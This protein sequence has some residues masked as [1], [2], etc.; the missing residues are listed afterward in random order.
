M[1]TA[2]D[3][4]RRLIKDPEYI[5]RED[6]ARGEAEYRARQHHNNVRAL[7][8]AAD[9]SSSI[10]SA[11]TNLSSFLSQTVTLMKA[12]YNN[13]GSAMSGDIDKHIGAMA[14]MATLP[15]AVQE[16]IGTLQSNGMPLESAQ[17][18]MELAQ[19]HY[20]DPDTDPEDHSW[21]NSIAHGIATHEGLKEQLKITPAMAKKLVT[22][23]NSA[24]YDL[25]P[26]YQAPTIKSSLKDFYGKNKKPDLESPATVDNINAA[27]KKMGRLETVQLGGTNKLKFTGGNSEQWKNPFPDK[28]SGRLYHSMIEGNEPQSNT[29]TI[30]SADLENYTVAQI[31]HGLHNY[32]SLEGGR[33]DITP[34]QKAQ[35]QQAKIDKEKEVAQQKVE[36][37]EILAT[38][39]SVENDSIPDNA[40]AAKEIYSNDVKKDKDAKYVMWGG[41]LNGYHST[42]KDGVAHGLCTVD[43][44]MTPLGTMLMHHA[45]SD[46]WGHKEHM[47]Y[48]KKTNAYVVTID[49]LHNIVEKFGLLP[50]KNMDTGEYHN[51]KII[52]EKINDVFKPL[53]DFD[54]GLEHQIE[55]AKPEGVPAVPIPEEE[56][57]PISDQSST[58]NAWDEI[59]NA[60]SMLGAAYEE[61]APQSIKNNL[62]SKLLDSLGKFNDLDQFGTSS[63]DM[64]DNVLFNVSDEHKSSVLSGIVGDKIAQGY[65]EIPYL[66]DH[67]VVKSIHQL[68]KA[69]EN[70][71]HS[72]N[73]GDGTQ[74]GFASA[75]GALED[76]KSSYGMGAKKIAE[77]PKIMSDLIKNQAP[78]MYEYI[79]DQIDVHKHPISQLQSMWEHTG[80]DPS[81]PDAPWNSPN[82]TEVKEKIFSDAMG[83][84]AST[85]PTPPSEESFH[86]SDYGTESTPGTHMVIHQNEDGQ[87][88]TTHVKEAT[89]EQAEG[90]ASATQGDKKYIGTIS[91]SSA[92]V[93]YSS[94]KVAEKMI[95]NKGHGQVHAPEISTS[96][97]TSTP[98][99]EDTVTPTATTTETPTT[100][101]AS[102]EETE[103]TATTPSTEEP[104][105]TTPQTPSSDEE[106]QVTQKHNAKKEKVMSAIFGD[107]LD[108]EDAQLYGEWLDENPKEVAGAYKQHVI[109][110][111]LNKIK[112]KAKN[113][114]K[115]QAEQIKQEKKQTEQEAAET[116]A[117]SEKD[118][119]QAVE[120]ANS[121]PHKLG[122]LKKLSEDDNFSSV[123]A[124]HHARE[125][126]AHKEK[127]GDK[128]KASTK[129]IMK[130]LLVEASEHGAD[131]NK[132]EDEMKEHGENFGSPEHM[133]AAHTADL[134]DHDKH[135]NYKD[136][137]TSQD[138]KHRQSREDSFHHGSYNKFTEFDEDGKP[139]T[140]T[141]VAMG[142]DG[143]AKKLDHKD[144]DVKPHGE[145]KKQSF[146]T[147]K[148]HALGTHHSLETLDPHQKFLADSYK[149]ATAKGDDEEAGKM[150]DKLEASGAD[151]SA[152]IG[153][154]H[155]DEKPKQGPPDPE[156]ARKKMAEGYVWHEETRH[157][158]KKETLD[159]LHG[160]HGA[161]DAS[162][163]S[164]SHGGENPFAFNESGGGSDKNFLLHGSGN[165]M[166]VG[167]AGAT[168]GKSGFASHNDVVENSL[169]HAL[170]ESG[171]LDGH[172]GVQHIPNFSH[173]TKGTNIGKR[174]GFN[175]ANKAHP[176]PKS[177]IASKVAAYKG[178][179]AEAAQAFKA[180][181]K[182]AP[183]AADMDSAVSGAV[184][185]ALSSL[186]PFSK[187]SLDSDDALQRFVKAYA[188]EDHHLTRKKK[189]E[190]ILEKKSII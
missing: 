150:L 2:N 163:I 15:E 3:I 121:L 181:Q 61:D 70:I 148:G 79:A 142:D 116:A 49:G 169:A 151:V 146:H 26:A 77:N 170:T 5:G 157:W 41:H 28:S 22:G 173:P 131:F 27:L 44:A 34:E 98:D 54:E 162:L 29:D 68:H 106:D 96:K 183:T 145:H 95:E 171:H 46:G 160:G 128:M 92:G 115:E 134:K 76:L 127:Y 165:L 153:D 72:F 36:E 30:S 14:N 184:S 19:N 124:T 190:E 167:K 45:K 180:G 137:L 75:I 47:Y 56:Q 111:V 52:Q 152:I 10:K 42:I 66:D 21:L 73:N 20:N 18:L 154:H 84:E 164:S 87:Y 125:L 133:D 64:V 38:S 65:P 80:Q 50:G 37:A 86:D 94:Q 126:L 156:V 62:H 188:S 32:V 51:E 135:T 117:Q 67:P 71:E 189:V 74:E 8:M 24:G 97:P 175:G 119:Q 23:L 158:I 90:L 185:S 35:H 143:R 91:D 13:L 57:E 138:S 123:T 122:D 48:H 161:H 82:F 176:N 60:G 110:G 187:K 166:G 113:A 16:F 25:P 99:E 100:P 11:V 114:E 104:E 177:G 85:I 81:H 132:L 105:V 33:Y 40:E 182:K 103:T 159:E 112:D 179:K 139:T 172:E 141:K 174:A 12:Y 186:N 31:L 78:E 17:G 130:K 118:E 108:N 59:N 69:I 149:A 144:N 7:A 168:P 129:Q 93:G 89:A 88:S 102:P 9:D 43:G 107:D 39:D 147:G 55:S 4:F 6:E 58:V 53:K 83:G 178:F 136:L 1:V 101:V 155:E 109:G 120:E 140:D 63:S